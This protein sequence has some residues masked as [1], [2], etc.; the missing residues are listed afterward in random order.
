M[1]SSA[2]VTVRAATPDDCAFVWET[3]NEE[4][5]RSLSLSTT[6]IPWEDHQRW[7]A[8]SL[9]S[10]TRQLFIV[11]EH[12]ERVGVM[13]LDELDDTHTVISIALIPGARGRGLG[14]DVLARAVERAH[15]SHAHVVAY[16]L[17]ENVRSIK[18]FKAAGFVFE[19][20]EIQG[21][22]PVVKMLATRA[23]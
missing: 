8:A 9:D 6:F 2:D 7:Y 23:S 12:A 19:S 14:R 21:D 16:I 5:V 17:P 22:R 3:N 11:M 4:H 15:Q 20:E 10:E 18:A 1:N 13:R